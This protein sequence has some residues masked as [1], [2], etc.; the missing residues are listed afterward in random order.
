MVRL[1]TGRKDI[2]YEGKPLTKIGED[3][4]SGLKLKV[5]KYFTTAQML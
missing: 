1:M 4:V 2:G 5:V 3:A